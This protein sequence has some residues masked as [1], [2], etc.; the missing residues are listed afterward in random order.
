MAADHGDE[1]ASSLALMVADDGNKRHHRWHCLAADD[2]DE[3]ASSLLSVLKAANKGDTH[4]LSLALMEAN[5][6]K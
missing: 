5:D 1:S 2:G 6:G 4:V 3:S